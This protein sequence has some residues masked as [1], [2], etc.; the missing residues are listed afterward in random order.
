MRLEREAGAL[1]AQAFAAPA[2]ALAEVEAR[3]A[4][5]CMP[6]RNNQISGCLM[7]AARPVQ[8]VS[9]VNQARPLSCEQRVRAHSGWPFLRCTVMYCELRMRAFAARQAI[10]ASLAAAEARAAAEAGEAARL[11][12]GLEAAGARLAMCRR[13]CALAWGRDGCTDHARA[14]HLQTY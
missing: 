7:S 13:V 2:T 9:A 5:S 8:V 4:A 12:A 1:R 11:R 10:G 14:H 3:P 6:S